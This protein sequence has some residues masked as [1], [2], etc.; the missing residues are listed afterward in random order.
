MCCISS[1]CQQPQHRL[2]PTCRDTPNRA[3]FTSGENCLY[4]AWPRAAGNARLA[5][6]LYVHFR[7]CTPVRGCHVLLCFSCCA[8]VLLMLCCS[9]SECMFCAACD[10]V[11]ARNKSPLIYRCT[12]DT[13]T[14]LEQSSAEYRHDMLCTMPESVPVLM[15]R[16]IP[17]LQ[18]PQKQR[19]RTKLVEQPQT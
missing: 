6:S 19:F 11:N 3:W 7:M 18:P 13:V 4:A 17:C 8:A 12:I 15:L 9:K 14:T 5:V 10:A 1:C 2:G 16:L